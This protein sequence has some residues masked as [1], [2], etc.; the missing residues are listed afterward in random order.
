M[1]QCCKAVKASL[2]GKA[3]VKVDPSKLRLRVFPV[4][5][6]LAAQVAQP[7]PPFLFDHGPPRVASFAEI[8]LQ[9]SLLCHAPPLAN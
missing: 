6:L 5:Q 9:R 7:A 4:V 3:E 2:S 8:V 1:M